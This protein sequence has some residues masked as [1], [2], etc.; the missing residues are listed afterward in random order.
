VL[1][2]RLSRFTSFMVILS[3]AHMKSRT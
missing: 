3:E 2:R 1:R